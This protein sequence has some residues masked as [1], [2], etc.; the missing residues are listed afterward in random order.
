MKHQL[1]RKKVLSIIFPIIITVAYFW[2]SKYT[3]DKFDY[4]APAVVYDVSYKLNRA[5]IRYKFK[6]NES[7]YTGFQKTSTYKN[8]KVGD[9]LIVI[10]NEDDPGLDRLLLTKSYESRIQIDSLNNLVHPQDFVKFIEF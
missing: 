3:Y 10:F 2:Y 9:T 6:Y 8:L 1:E 5:I 7:E 4:Y